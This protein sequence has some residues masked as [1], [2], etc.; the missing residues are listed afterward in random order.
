MKHYS[1]GL[2]LIKLIK[3]RINEQETML[4][5]LNLNTRDRF[6]RNALYWAI[7]YQRV[8]DVKLL[9]D[10]G[11][12]QNVA[13]KLDALSHAIH[14]GNQAIISLLDREERIALSA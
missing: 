7:S 12:S 4:G 9:L 13:P 6:S 1:D 5:R 3:N 14:I 10:H 8:E 11:I 2:F